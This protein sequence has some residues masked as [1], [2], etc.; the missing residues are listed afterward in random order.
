[1]AISGFI[2][3]LDWG[4]DSESEGEGLTKQDCALN[5]LKKWSAKDDTTYSQLYITGP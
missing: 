3:I 2:S 5:M 4:Q 1:M